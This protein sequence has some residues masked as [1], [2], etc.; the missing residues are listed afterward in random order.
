MELIRITQGE[1][2]FGD[3]KILDNADLRINQGERVCLVGKNG[4]GKS[5]LLKVLMQKQALDDGQLIFSNNIRLAMLEQDPP[6]SCDQTVFDFV[7]QGLQANAELLKT[8]HL[9]TTQV[10]QQAD[11]KSL[12][13]LARIQQQLDQANAWQDELRIEQVLSTLSL[14]ADTNIANLSGGWLRRL[15]LAKALVTDPDVLL[16]DEPTN[17][18]DI[19]S[20]QWLENFLLNLN[21]TIVFI[22]HDRAFIRR[23]ATR[24]VDLDRGKLTNYPGNY[25]QYVEQKQHDLQVEAQHNALFDKKLAEEEAWIRQGIKARRTRNE[26]RVRALERLRREREQRRE[27]KKQ[28]QMNLSLGERSGKLVFEGQGITMTFGNKTVIKP[29]DL[30]ITRGDR[31]ALIG[32]NGTGKST[33]LKIIMGQLTPTAGK[34]KLGVNLEIAYFDQHRDELDGNKTVQDVVA[35]GKQDVTIAGKTRHVLGYLQDFL[36]SPKRAR[37]PVRALSGGEKNRLLLAK[38]FLKPSN[39]LI[40]DEPTN[41]LDIETLELL[42]DVVANYAGTV[43]LV[44]HDRDFVNNCVSSCLYFDGSGH[45]EQIVGGYDDVE[46]YLQQKSQNSSANSPATDVKQPKAKKNTE[47][48]VKSTKKK[49]S[50]KETRELAELPE[51]IESLELAIEQLQQQINSADFFS[52]PTEITAPILNQLA[53]TESKLEAAYDRWQQ[54]DEN[55]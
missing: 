31:I 24:I 16:L 38:L 43:I 45:V 8:Y 53:E 13:E 11:E 1:L 26:G 28:G 47:Q 21:G 39:L 27:V 3:D 55:T 37:T 48:P 35:D 15:A 42:E 22:S 41:D 17:H 49:L 5:S 12:A 44:S 6:Q 20:V 36:F 18:L 2:A 29:L 19:A 25:D 52:Q 33:L 34:I 32:A 9:L 4:A 46:Q 51:I 7:A 40:L 50:Y 23:L 10:S 54:L 14:N 30:L